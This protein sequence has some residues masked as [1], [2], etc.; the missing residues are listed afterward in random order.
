MRPP[1]PD[2]NRRHQCHADPFSLGQADVVAR[3]GLHAGK[4][5]VFAVGDVHRVGVGHRHVQGGAFFRFHWRVLKFMGIDPPLTP[6]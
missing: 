4:K 2:L 3:L 5:G 1:K 6:T